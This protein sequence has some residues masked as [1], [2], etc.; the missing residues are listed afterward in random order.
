MDI[1]I[2][3]LE[4]SGAL[5]SPLP[6]FSIS[7]KNLKVVAV[8]TW[9]GHSQSSLHRELAPGTT[10]QTPFFYKILYPP[11]QGI[12]NLAFFN[13][14]W[15]SLNVLARFIKIFQTSLKFEH[16]F[17]DKDLSEHSTHQIWKQM[18]WFIEL[19]ESCCVRDQQYWQQL[20]HS[21]L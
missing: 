15:K 17:K 21:W 20:H 14:G 8:W 2:Q 9:E 6:L 10:K 3:W 19:Q 7:H 12:H 16:H 4:G 13:S 11:Q 18:Q 5:H 1:W